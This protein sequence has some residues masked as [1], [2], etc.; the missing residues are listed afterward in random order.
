[1]PPS[2]QAWAE[3]QLLGDRKAKSE[4]ESEA[5]TESGAEKSE[6]KPLPVPIPASWN[7]RGRLGE[8]EV[9]DVRVE[10]FALPFLR[11][12]VRAIKAFTL[13]GSSFA[14]DR[15]DIDH[16]KYIGAFFDLKADAVIDVAHAGA[17]FRRF[18]L[19]LDECVELVIFIYT[20]FEFF[21]FLELTIFKITIR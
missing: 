15:G 13:E 2:L 9:P 21:F 1:M 16:N 6:Q 7:R 4:S 3:R 19:T 18:E 5:K 20:Y 12:H 10:L 11:K 8:G 14:H 17:A